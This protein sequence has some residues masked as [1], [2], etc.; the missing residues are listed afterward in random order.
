MTIVNTVRVTGSH[1]RVRDL[2]PL[3]ADGEPTPW[4]AYF[5]HHERVGL[6]F[7]Y[8]GS[9]GTMKV[10]DGQGFGATKLEAVDAALTDFV[11]R[12]L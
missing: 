12:R 6:G 9:V 2:T 5:C 1:L 7:P 3:L 4:L 11:G 8:Y 10:T